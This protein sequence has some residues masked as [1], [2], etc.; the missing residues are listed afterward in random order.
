MCRESIGSRRHVRKDTACDEFINSLNLR[1]IQQQL[2][3]ANPHII[4]PFGVRYKEQIEQNKK[5]QLQPMDIDIAHATHTEEKEQTNTTN[6]PINEQDLKQN[7]LPKIKS[8]YQD[9]NEYLVRF[10]PLELIKCKHT[11]EHF[12]KWEVWC[13]SKALCFIIKQRIAN[14][15][16]LLNNSRSI[17]IYFNANSMEGVVPNRLVAIEN[18]KDLTELGAIMCGIFP[19]RKH[20]EIVESQQVALEESDKKIML[21]FDNQMMHFDKRIHAGREYLF[22]GRNMDIVIKQD[23]IPTS[24]NSPAKPFVMYYNVSD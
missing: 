14:K 20:N 1:S 13:R 8:K 2:D 10:E 3:R 24:K 9:V 15:I 18:A 5:R 4:T 19:V 6:I 17:R 21:Q 22:G 11:G 7:N 23:S 16:G 12:P